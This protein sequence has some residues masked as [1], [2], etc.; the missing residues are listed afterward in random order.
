MIDNKQ[1]IN[2][3]DKNYIVEDLSDKAQYYLVQLQELNHKKT[4]TSNKL[5]Q[6]QIALE[7]FSALLR[8]EVTNPEQRDGED[9]T[10]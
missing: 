8:E 1:T 10:E 3:D 9:F 4:S 6:I 2:I 7:G 5:H